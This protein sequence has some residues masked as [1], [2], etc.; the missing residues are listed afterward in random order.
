MTGLAVLSSPENSILRAKVSKFLNLSF[1]VGV[2]GKRS[3]YVVS[4]AVLKLPTD[5][6]MTLRQR[7][8]NI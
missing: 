7:L 5:F 1:H 4:Y 2:E 6:C 8:T 3:S